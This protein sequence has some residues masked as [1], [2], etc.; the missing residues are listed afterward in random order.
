MPSP[1]GRVVPEVC[2]VLRP[3]LSSVT[4]TVPVTHRT[5]LSSDTAFPGHLPSLPHF[6]F[7]AAVS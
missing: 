1:I 5:D 4:V 3:K 7:P 6:P 2:S